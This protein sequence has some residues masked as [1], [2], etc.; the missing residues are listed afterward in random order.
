MALTVTDQTTW[1]A[2]INHLN[3]LHYMEMEMSTAIDIDERLKSMS[4]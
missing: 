2:A 3:S 1:Q 4:H